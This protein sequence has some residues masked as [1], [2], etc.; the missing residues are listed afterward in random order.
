MGPGE[1]KDRLQRR[2]AGFLWSQWGQMGMPAASSSPSPWAADPEALAL[3]SLEVGREDPRL[4]DET[5]DWLL[6]NERLASGQRLR[7]LAVDA[8]DRALAD[9]ASAW[10]SQWRRKSRW[11]EPVP[12]PSEVGEPLYVGVRQPL[13]AVDPAFLAAGLLK[14]LRE[15]DRRSQS[16]DL[17]VPINLAFRLRS[18]LGVGARAEVVRV[19]LTVDAPRTTVQALAVSTGYAKR[20]AQEAAAALRAAGVASSS[21]LGNE[22]RF[23]LDRGRWL[24]LL[25]LEMPPRHVDWPQFLH[26]MRVLLRWLRDN[27]SAGLSEYMLASGARQVLE[28]VGDDFRFA[29]IPVSAAGPDGTAYWQHFEQV[30][31]DLPYV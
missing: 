25:G 3:T 13:G 2:L 15:P 16:P 4:F 12:P 22:Q 5:L 8:A 7:N 10:V 6:V 14:P 20:N 19:L 21:S 11:P 18:V 30:V 23:E 9:A 31:E 28:E 1:L 17:L 27:E 24:G 29:G 26:A